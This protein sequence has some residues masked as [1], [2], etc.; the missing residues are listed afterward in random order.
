MGQNRQNIVLKLKN[1][2]KCLNLMLFWGSLTIYYIK[3]HIQ[4]VDSVEI[5]HKTCY[6]LDRGQ[7]AVP[8]KR[9][10]LHRDWIF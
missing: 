5:E 10:T 6:F 3:M 9:Q 4:G 8:L 2:L 1:R 7:D